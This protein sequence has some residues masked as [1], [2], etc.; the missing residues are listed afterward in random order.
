MSKPTDLVQG[1]LDLLILKIIA[2]EPT[3][4]WA[5]A[6]RIRQIV[7][8]ACHTSR[9]RDARKNGGTH[10]CPIQPVR[11]PSPMRSGVPIRRA[12]LSLR[13]SPLDR[14]RRKVPRG[15]AYDREESRPHFQLAVRCCRQTAAAST[16]V[17]S[18]PRAAINSGDPEVADEAMR[19]HI[20]YGFNSVVTGI[21]PSSVEPKTARAR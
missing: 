1:T 20:R 5:I 7:R 14:R 15:Q 6:Q 3:H 8:R 11:E 4:G 12:E 9:P 18:R 21:D 13:V 16:D 10:G 17:P 2:L 19:A